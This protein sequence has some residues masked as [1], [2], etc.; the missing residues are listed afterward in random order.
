MNEN[1]SVE[2]RVS[3]LVC[4]LW[5]SGGPGKQSC[6]QGQTSSSVWTFTSLTEEHGTAGIS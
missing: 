2:T 4:K 5:S 1:A 3:G 6:P